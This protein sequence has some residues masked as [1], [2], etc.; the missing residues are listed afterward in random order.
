MTNFALTLDGRATIDGRSGAIGSETDT[1]MLVGL[2]TRVDAVMIGAGTMR[3]EHYGRLVRKAERRELREAEG[4]RADPLL[5]IVSGRLDLPWDAPAFTEKGE[6]L[7]F[8]SSD[9]EPPDTEAEVRV[10][11]HEGTVDIGEA[12]S[13]M[14]KEAGIRGLLCEGG[15]HLHGELHRIDAV[16]EMFV[17]HA[18]A[19]SGGDGP[20]LVSG[21]SPFL[22]KLEFGWLVLEEETSELFARYVVMREP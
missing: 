11:R 17:T 1:S 20:G 18:P 4:L 22:R 2:R 7:I 14:R 21:L 16:D 6:V 5:V 19:L 12:L 8:T 13:H 15:A 3:A 10:V 9:E